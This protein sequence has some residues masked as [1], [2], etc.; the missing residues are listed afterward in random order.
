[1]TVGRHVLDGAPVLLE[2]ML[3]HPGWH[4]VVVLAGPTRENRHFTGVVVAADLGDQLPEAL[5][6]SL[7]ILA[8]ASDRADWRLD[9]ALTRARDAG[10]SALMISGTEPVHRSTALLAT[11]LGLP[12]LGTADTLGAYLHL[13]AVLGQAAALR[14]EL[15]VRTTAACQRAGG[16]VEDLLAELNRTFERPVALYDEGS[17]RVAGSQLLWGPDW[18]EAQAHLHFQRTHPAT[19]VQIPLPSGGV[20]IAHP[21]TGTGQISWIAAGLPFELRAE[22][23]ALLGAL[24]VAAIAMQERLALRRLE[25]ERDAR[26]RS[27]LL[28][29]LLH[30]PAE[31]PLGL[32]RRALDLGWRLDGWQ[33]AVHIGILGEI[34]VTESL[35]EVEAAFAAEGVDVVVVERKDGWA[36]WASV[37]RRPTAAEVTKFANDIRRVQRR[38]ADT[39]ETYVGVGRVHTGPS[40]IA[41]SLAEASDAARLARRR[42][43]SGHFVHVDRLGVAQLLLAWT[44]TDSFQPAA[45]ELL[46]PLNAESGELLKT[47][48]AYLDA[49]SSVAETAA[50]L[51]IHRNTVSSR[52]ARIQDCLHVDLADPETRL[53]LHLACRTAY[54]VGRAD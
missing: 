32:R 46:D 43:E 40:G 4:G 48:S 5:G 23:D 26:Y 1:M 12:L 54:H 39:L 11:R 18:Y 10:A 47:L 27:S 38:L 3:A 24:A 42:A 29:E 37:D 53:A 30:A 14:A 17:N 22:S 49:E 51:G 8:L 44:Q 31:L 34:D 52:V 41:R 28:E 50:V 13:T 36:A 9:A 45:R 7:L 20:L 25:A 15:I 19:G 21:L 35:P 16:S 6:G 2:A 33:T